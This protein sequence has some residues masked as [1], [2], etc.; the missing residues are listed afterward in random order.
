MVRFASRRRR[1]SR[2]PRRFGRRVFKRRST[3]RMRRGSRGELKLNTQAIG[4]I[5][6]PPTLGFVFPLTENI[7]QGLLVTQRIGNWITPRNIHGNLVVKGNQAAAPG[8]DSFLVRTGI[9]CW[10]ND[11]QFDSPDVNQI[12]QDPLAPLGPL[13]FAQRGSFR[14][15]WGRNFVIMNDDDNSQ[16]IKKFPF[17]IKLRPRRTVYDANNPKKYQYFFFILSDS[18]VADAPLFNLDITLRYTDS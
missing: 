13:N 12:V 16:Y 7:Q 1:G 14:Q 2:K 4:P 18:I 15:V 5:I 8:T 3:R 6:I 10:K 9:F 11:V 17:Y